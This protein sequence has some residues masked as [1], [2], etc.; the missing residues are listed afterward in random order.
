[1]EL[2]KAL[3]VVAAVTW[4]GGGLTLTLLVLRTERTDDMNRL[5]DLGAHS[6]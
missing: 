5:L 2:F 6:D 1:M 4:V 3:H